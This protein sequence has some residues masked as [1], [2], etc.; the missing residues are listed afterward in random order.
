MDRLVI[1][2]TLLSSWGYMY[3]CYEDSQEDAYNDFL[4]TLR[5]EPKEQTDAMLDGIEFENEV[6]KIVRGEERVPHE[7]WEN[8][9]QAVASRLN[10]AAIQVK[11]SADF[12]VDGQPIHLYGILDALKAGVIYDVKFTTHSFGSTELAGKYFESPQHP[13]Y[14][15]IVPEA[16]AFTYL[17][18]DGNDLY[19]ETY[20]RDEY[21]PIEETIGNFLRY[22]KDAGLMPIYQERWKAK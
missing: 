12:V 16:L 22:L 10:G 15:R 11:G 5:K 21:T 20:R 3:S 6:Y 19:A 17:V 13:A 14:L 18:S 8:G 7:K 4:L 2:Q 9:I 1:T